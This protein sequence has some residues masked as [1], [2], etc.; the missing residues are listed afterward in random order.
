[1]RLAWRA[2][3]LTEWISPMTDTTTDATIISI[4]AKVLL[5]LMATSAG[6]AAFESLELAPE[7]REQVLDAYAAAAAERARDDAYASLLTEYGVSVAEQLIAYGEELAELVYTWGEVSR[8]ARHPK[9][10]LTKNNR[11]YDI[12]TMRGMVR[13]TVAPIEGDT[14]N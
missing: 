3:T 7:V 14:R 2:D 13:V 10:A 8:S 11:F 1:M 9:R 6:R 5:G 12:P 4:D